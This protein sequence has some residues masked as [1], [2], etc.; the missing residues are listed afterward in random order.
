M[1]GERTKLIVTQ[2]EHL[3]SRETRRLRKE[4]IVPGV[5]YGTGEPVAIA[6]AERE[7]RRALTGCRR[8]ALHPRRRDR[9][10]RQDASVDP[11][12]LPAGQRAR[13]CHARRP[14]GGPPRPADHRRGDRHAHRRRERA[15]RARGRRALAAAAR[16]EHRGAS[17]RDSRASRPRRF[18]PVHRRRAPRRR[19]DRSGRREGAGRARDRGRERHRSD[20]RRR[21]GR[22]RAK[23]PP[24]ARP[25]ARRPRV[26]PTRVAP[27]RKRPATPTPEEG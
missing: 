2:R 19:P 18:G 8:P 25:R 22:R 21:G 9:R 15:G 3:G 27:S 16:A 26:P 13:R 6:V 24:R 1:A 12:G 11:Q 4:G 7:L 14:P 23:R 5:L 10:P 17:A 20:A